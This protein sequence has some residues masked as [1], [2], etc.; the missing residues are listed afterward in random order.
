M[1]VWWAE[2]WTTVQRELFTLPDPVSTMRLCVRSLLAVLLG[3]IVGYER[4]RR[5]SAAGL[6]IHMLVALGAALFVMVPLEDGVASADMSRVLQGLI[7]GIGFLGAG[8]VIKLTEDRS[9]DGVTTAASIWLTAA[10]GVA[11]GMGMAI[12]AAMAT[13]FSLFVLAQL[14]RRSQ[15]E[16]KR[17]EPAPVKRE[18]R[19]SPA[20]GRASSPPRLQNIR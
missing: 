17:V 18:V 6:R 3:G 12:A 10:I 8:A 15:P 14:S 2:A 7:S 9:V 11:A 16:L 20:T 19:N 5:H 4:E 13:G 1:E